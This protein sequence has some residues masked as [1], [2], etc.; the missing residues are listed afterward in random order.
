MQAWRHSNEL[1]D[2]LQTTYYAKGY[3]LRMLIYVYIY[4]QPPTY[5]LKIIYM[6]R[7]ITI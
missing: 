3:S 1:N 5:I 4:L 6:F 7:Y 2:I